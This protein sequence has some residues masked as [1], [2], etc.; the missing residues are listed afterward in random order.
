MSLD[1]M[2]FYFGPDQVVPVAS[3]LA[4]LAGLVLI[5]WNRVVRVVHRITGHLRPPAASDA[6]DRPANEQP[7]HQP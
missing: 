7:T 4:T 2:G 6:V 5:F 3:I 1:L